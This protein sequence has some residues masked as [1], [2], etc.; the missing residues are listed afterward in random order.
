MRKR[1]FYVIFLV[2]M[3]AIGLFFW[4]ISFLKSEKLNVVDSVLNSQEA[5]ILQSESTSQNVSQNQNEDVEN[6]DSNKNIAEIKN[7]DLV[8]SWQTEKNK[9]PF[10]SQAPLGNWSDERLQNGC[11]E[12]SIIMAMKWV[13]GEIFSS[14]GDAQLEI[15][16]ISKFEEKIFG[17]SVDSSIEGVGEIFSQFF[18]FKNFTIS[19]NFVLDDLKNELEKGGI[20]LVP[21]YGRALKNPNYTPP[22]PITHMLVIVGYDKKTKEF[23]TNDPGTKKGEN[24]HYDENVLFDAIWAYPA[25]KDHHLPPKST[26]EKAMLVIRH[27]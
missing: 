18:G 9:V 6:N 19:R 22:G 15:I 5:G 20:I 24:Y 2:V 14:P 25:G 23:V 11:E 16:S 17:N 27:I 26:K 21:T 13:Q 7:D 3:L 1:I 4:R 8:R 10:T 12:T